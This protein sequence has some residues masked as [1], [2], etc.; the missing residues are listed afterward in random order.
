MVKNASFHYLDL[1]IF[2]AFNQYFKNGTFGK[3][4]AYSGLS[5]LVITNKEWSML[6]GRYE[7]VNQYEIR[8][9]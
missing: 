6:Q 9:M 3:I 8:L 7:D 4:S 2:L 5:I 1:L